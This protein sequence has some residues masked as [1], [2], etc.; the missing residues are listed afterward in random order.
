MACASQLPLLTKPQLDWAARRWPEVPT[1]QIESGRTLY[2][3]KCSGCHTLKQPRAYSAERWPKIME[4]MSPKAKLSRE[5]EEQITRYVSTMLEAPP[6][7]PAR[8]GPE[9]PGR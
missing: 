2:V 5:Q 7:I 1:S 9:A 8:A 3:M 4:K 6:D